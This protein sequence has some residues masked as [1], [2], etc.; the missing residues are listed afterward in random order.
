MSLLVFV[1]SNFISFGQEKTP[2]SSLGISG[3]AVAD[4]S[5]CRRNRTDIGAVKNFKELESV[6]VLMD[7]ETSLVFASGFAQ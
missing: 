5:L 7:K 1:G 3:C 2:Q 4:K 6:F